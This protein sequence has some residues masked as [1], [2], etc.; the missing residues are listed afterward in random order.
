LD[1][2]LS[3]SDKDLKE[4]YTQ[5]Q[6]NYRQPD[7]L[8]FAQVFFDPD[9]RD[10]TTIID[11]EMALASLNTMG[12]PTLETTGFGDPFLLQNYYPRKSNQEISKLFGQGFTESIFE[13][14]PGSWYGP[15]LSGYGVHLVYIFESIESPLPEFEDVKNEIEQDWIVSKRQ[16]LQDS[17][18]ESIIGSYQVIVED[19]LEQP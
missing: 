11:A 3:S 8:T 17:Y 10:A 6:D 4:F 5:N 19:S 14:E 12:E 1:M 16:D 7:L 9:L 13:L 18:I 15:I 2:S